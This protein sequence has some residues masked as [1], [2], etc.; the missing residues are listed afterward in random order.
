MSMSMSKSKRALSSSSQ[1]DGLAPLLVRMLTTLL[2]IMAVLIFITT[3]Y[4]FHLHHAH[5][6]VDTSDLKHAFGE[7]A[8]GPNSVGGSALRHKVDLAQYL[9]NKYDTANQELGQKEAE[10]G[11]WKGGDEE[12][13]IKMVKEMSQ[14]K[15]TPVKAGAATND[16]RKE[17]TVDKADIGT[18]VRTNLALPPNNW[19]ELQ[20]ALLDT[21]LLPTPIPRTQTARGYSGLPAD[22]TPAL[23][24]ALRGQ[25]YCPD[26]HPK[27]QEVLNSMLAFWNDPRGTRD[28]DPTHPN[29][30]LY[31]EEH[32]HPFLPKPLPSPKN[33][34]LTDPAVSKAQ[35]MSWAKMRGKYLTFE[36]DTA[37]SGRALVLPPDQNIYLLEPKNG[38]KRT[39]RNYYDLFN[40][41]E[42]TELLRRVPI[43]TAKEFLEL[44][45]GENGLVPLNEYNA[46]YQKNLWAVTEEC[47]DRKKSDVFCD[48]VYDHYWKHGLLADI[49]A[50]PPTQD[51]VI[52]DAD[53]YE[54]GPE[55]YPLLPSEIQHRVDEFCHER[56]KVFY[57]KTMHDTPIWHFE[58]LTTRYRLLVHFYSQNI[59]TDPILENFYKRFIRD[60]LRYHNDAMCAAG[61][62]ILALQYEG[63]ALDPNSGASMDLDSELVGGYS[64]LH[65]RRGDLQFTEVRIEAVDWKPYEPLYIATDERVKSWFNDLKNRHSGPL[66][67]LSSYKYLVGLDDLDI[68]VYGLVDTLV[69][70]RGSMFAGTWFSSFSGYIVRLRGYFG[71]SKFQ[72]YYSWLQR[73]YFMHKWMNT[74]EAS[75][76]AREYPTGW[77]SIDGDAFVK[78]DREGTENPFEGRSGDLQKVAEIV[79]A[80]KPVARGVSGLPLGQTKA[81]FGARRAIITCDED[82]SKLAY[83]N[84]PQGDR[85]YIFTTPYRDKTPGAKP[86]YLAFSMDPGG[87]NNVRMSMEIVFIIAAITGRTLILPPDQPMY[88]LG[89]DRTSENK[90]RG[91]DD[92]FDM[93]GPS[94]KKRVDVITMEDFM[95]KEAVSGGQFVLEDS[96]YAELIDLAGRG[97]KKSE[98][99]CGKIHNYLVKYGVTPNITATHHQ[100]LVIDDGM[101]VR[102]V[103]DFPERAQ[104]FCSSGNREIVYLTK[105]LNQPTL[106]YIQAEKPVTRMLAHFYG[107]ITFT[108]PSYDNYFKRFVRDLLHYR[109]EIFCAA[110]KIINTLQLLGQDHGFSLEAEGN[111]GYSSLHIRRGDFQYK[112]MKL[113]AHEWYNN[114]KDFEQITT[115]TIYDDNQMGMLETVVASQGRVFVGTF[116]STFSGYINRLRGYYGISMMNSFYGDLEHKRIMHEWNNVNLDT[117]AKEWPDAWIGIDGDKHPSKDMF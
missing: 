106:L 76:F 28:E 110:G 90:R 4:I 101:Y 8:N 54:K 12:S 70:S 17:A 15:E 48:H 64:S 25:F 117:Y 86:K 21:N 71:M 91:L 100:C 96:E 111:G 98:K 29:K 59:F 78:E 19:Q 73:K 49:S 104:E 18:K 85:D 57:N 112:K 52:F 89:N 99:S 36:P 30:E 80:N 113:S 44:E 115:S 82:V 26:T 11:G 72:T 40:L 94:F 83:W 61:K 55:H 67:Y 38:D 66:R 46:T 33:N 35:R 109:H 65:I 75:L 51:C 105:D 34:D 93:R 88:L 56:R 74:W 81:V 10:R 107:Y 16:E 97:C 58:T 27:V 7:N 20:Q 5:H 114:T 42:H 53:V 31:N 116:R 14:E 22:Q 92:F 39:G 3:L 37:V 47:E 43:L 62:I 50:E 32:P 63:Y 60:F 24:G 23:N 69:A 68:T 84:E 1:E 77:T 9:M 108:D 6:D 95:K 41:T 45:G 87:F 13:F 79:N 2:P 102:G 103:P